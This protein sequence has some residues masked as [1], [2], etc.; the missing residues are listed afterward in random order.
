MAISKIATWE[1]I[2]DL[3]DSI[4]SGTTYN[5]CPTYSKIIALSGVTVSGTYA[6]NQLVAYSDISYVSPVV[7][8]TVTNSNYTF[9]YINE[10][11]DYI[12]NGTCSV[13][14]TFSID[15]SDDVTVII[16]DIYIDTPISSIGNEHFVSS[17]PMSI[18]NGATLKSLSITGNIGSTQTSTAL[19]L[20]TS[21]E[22]SLSSSQVSTGT[23]T[24]TNVLML[25]NIGYALPDGDYTMTL[26]VTVSVY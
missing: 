11:D 8:R 22:L 15:G 20:T 1:D 18:P 25:D 6:D 7:M 24:P 2:D 12:N 5:Q 19:K 17:R 26:N 3:I 16:A 10:L 13:T 23:N 4:P 9:A 21:G 14:A